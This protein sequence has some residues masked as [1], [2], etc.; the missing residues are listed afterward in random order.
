[1]SKH[2]PGPW[3]S[4]DNGP[5][6]DSYIHALKNNGDAFK[7]VAMIPIKT[8]PKETRANAQLIAAAPEMLAALER[9]MQLQVSVQGD[10][11]FDQVVAAIKKAK[12]EA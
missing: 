8:N 3:V 6:F 1:V 9:V 2:T 7:F 11:V 12:G 4:S 5:A 10:E